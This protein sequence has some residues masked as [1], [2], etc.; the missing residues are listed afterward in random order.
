[1][2]IDILTLF[3]EVFDFLYN[4]SIVGRAITNGIININ[5]TNI[6]DYS[7]N[8]HNKVDDYPFGGGK[9]MV[10][11]PEPLAAAIKAQRTAS[12]KIIYMSPQ[13][14]LLTQNK[15]KELS[16]ESHIILLAGHYE[17]IDNRIIENYVDE[18]IS[19]GDYVLTGGEIPVM[20][21][22]ESIIRLIP[23]VLSSNESFE[24]ESHYNGLLEYPQYTRPRIFEKKKVPEILL[25]GDHAKIEQ[26]RKL[27]SLKTTLEKRPDLIS[28]YTNLN[29]ELELL[30]YLIERISKES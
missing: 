3:P 28:K 18:E 29:N 17:G 16:Q 14:Q 7:N 21:L 23:G 26:W 22:I 8:K 11:K 25:S 19:I 24:V 12:S 5:T 20:V 15:A 9:G 2:K 30:D 13:G 6:R 1:M 27:K 10:I 4:Y